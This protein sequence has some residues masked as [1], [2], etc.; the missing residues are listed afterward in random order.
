MVM[1]RLREYTLNDFTVE[2]RLLSIASS[3]EVSSPIPQ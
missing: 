2:Q 1:P 3:R